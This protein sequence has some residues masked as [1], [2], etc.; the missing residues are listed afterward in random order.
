[1][2][3][4]FHF[5]FQVMGIFREWMENS[6][7]LKVYEVHIKNNQVRYLQ[8]F[9]VDFNFE[10]EKCTKATPSETWSIRNTS[11]WD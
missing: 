3:L 6:T 4:Y 2:F 9:F 10:R 7:T 8:K 1:M 5:Q 11:S